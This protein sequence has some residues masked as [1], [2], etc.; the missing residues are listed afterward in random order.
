[1]GGRGRVW[2]GMGCVRSSICRG[3]R[4]RRG[5][6]LGLGG[7]KLGSWDEWVEGDEERG[8]VEKMCVLLTIMK[9]AQ[10]IWEEQIGLRASS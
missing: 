7:R 10:T 2:G 4:R 6:S 3:M 8:E 1:M 5:S 9:G